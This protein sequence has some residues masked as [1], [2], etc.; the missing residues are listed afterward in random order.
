MFTKR[1]DKEYLLK[2]N[3]CRLKMKAT[4]IFFYRRISKQS[5]FIHI[6]E[7]Y[8]AIKK[9]KL[10]K[11]TTWMNLKIVMLKN[12]SHIQKIRVLRSMNKKINLR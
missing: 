12:K 7:Y 4:Q 6:M 5:V 10:L 2:L 9:K 8:W 11:H 1:L 3:L